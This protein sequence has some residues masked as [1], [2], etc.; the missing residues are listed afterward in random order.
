MIF[1]SPAAAR[2]EPAG[3]KAT[4]RTGFTSPTAGLVSI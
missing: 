2:R 1:E 4:V 3:E